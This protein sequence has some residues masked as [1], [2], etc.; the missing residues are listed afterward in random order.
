[1]KAAGVLDRKPDE[2]ADG[3]ELADMTPEQINRA[4]RQATADRKQAEA[5]ILRL[6]RDASRPRRRR[7]GENENAFD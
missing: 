4:L 3:A 6:E 2:D 7:K 1:M 5:V